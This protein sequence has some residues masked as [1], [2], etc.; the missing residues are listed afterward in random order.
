MQNTFLII[1]YLFVHLVIKVLGV[2]SVPV[3]SKPSLSADQ[4]TKL[5]E[6]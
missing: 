1:F 5:K 2:D 6:M 4:N 3:A